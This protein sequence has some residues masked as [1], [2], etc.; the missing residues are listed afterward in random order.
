[1][2]RKDYVQF[3]AMLSDLF[4]AINTGNQFTTR[5]IFA[6]TLS[7]AQP[8]KEFDVLLQRYSS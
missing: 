4:A 6:K 7:P 3:A 2:S 5:R 8:G 1:M